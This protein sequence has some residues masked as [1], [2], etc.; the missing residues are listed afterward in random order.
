MNWKAIVLWIISVL[1]AA[2]FVMAGSGKL[3][4]PAQ[5]Q[6]AFANYGYPAWF[7]TVIGIVETLGGLLVLVPRVAFYAA[8]ALAVV[9]AG[10]TFSHLKTAGE[11]PRAVVPIVLF[12]LS[13]VVALAR[14]PKA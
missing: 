4:N 8:G 3:F 7:V 6:A 10:A 5:F 1:L 9:M 14:R 2:M 12:I 11:A 13:V